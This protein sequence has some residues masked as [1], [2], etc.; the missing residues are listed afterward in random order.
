VPAGGAA[1]FAFTDAWF[2]IALG[3][4]NFTDAWFMIALGELNGLVL[5][6]DCPVFVLLAADT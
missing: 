2:M 1:G 3:E 6:I 4:L 5:G